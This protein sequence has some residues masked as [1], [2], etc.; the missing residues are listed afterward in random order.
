MK[1]VLNFIAWKW[2][3]FDTWQKIWFFGM[4]WFGGYITAPKGSTHELVCVILGFGALAIVFFKWMVWDMLQSSWEE[5]NKEQE[6]IVEIM[7]NGA[8]D[9]RF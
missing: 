5:Y 4:F 1:K 9:R 3:K 8:D 7:K 2:N 6:Q